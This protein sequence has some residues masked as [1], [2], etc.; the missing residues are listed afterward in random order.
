MLDLNQILLFIAAVS[1]AILL[2]QTWRG[3][4]DPNW[5]TGALT[6]LIVTS[7]AWML[8][9]PQ[10]GFIGGGAWFFLLFL[11]A[12]LLRKA[13]ELA[14]RGE[15]PKARRLLHALRLLHPR[16]A[17]REH[18]RVIDVMERAHEHGRAL[19]A[20]GPRPSM[21]GRT[22]TR[23]TR[24]V[25]L[26]IALNAAMFITQ[27]VLG[28]STNLLTLHRLGALEPYAV[29][30]NS[31]YWRMVTALFL[32]Y[33]PAHLLVNLFALYFF[34]PTVESALGSVR[35]AACYLISGIG[36]CAEIAT[37]WRFGWLEMDQLVGA[38]AA[39][40]GIVGAWAG[41]LIRDRHLANN[42]RTLRNIMI[43]I[44]VQCVF[45]ILT[46]RVSMAAHLSGLATGFV[47][48]LLLAPRRASTIAAP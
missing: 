5:R 47:V 31:E 34:G 1:P 38:S 36:S 24:V 21:F 35:F 25:A 22:R 2:V 46:P 15:V 17:L 8:A 4:A 13:M 43:I 44:V 41:A 19:P 18:A 23:L 11:P 16:Q 9:R 32:H 39:V 45:D 28:G 40:M 30:N 33:G 7:I 27:M 3:A 10:A 37:L 29:L 26:V 14:Q 20:V 6:V 42:R 12:T 48:G